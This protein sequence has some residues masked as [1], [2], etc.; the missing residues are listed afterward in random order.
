VVRDVARSTVVV[1]SADRPVALGL[2]VDADATQGWLVTKASELGD[3][4]NVRFRDGKSALGQV[5]GVSEAQDLAL[6]K[7]TARGLLAAELATDT[8]PPVG[9]WVATSTTIDK[10]L[11]LGIIS[12]G[13]RRIGPEMVM[14]GLTLEDT[15]GGCKVIQVLPRSPAEKA[16]LRAG[17]ILRQIAG[18]AAATRA[19]VQVLMRSHKAGEP[20]AVQVERE[21]KSLTFTAT[22]EE[23]SAL[24][25]STHPAPP[26]LVPLSH[27]HSGFSAVL[28]HDTILRPNECGGPLIDLDGRVV[29]LNIARATRTETYALP[30]AL[31]AKVVA[32]L[33]AAPATLPAK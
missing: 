30:A 20:I 9:S 21:G 25:T 7:V 3:H 1:R 27:R 13:V 2:I 4:L 28:T 10:P 11:A 8:E 22:P 6:V 14:L 15:D 18:E 17:D 5:V 12:V 24:M 29:G 16:G 31:V 26:Q 32:E 23:A 33:R 19:E